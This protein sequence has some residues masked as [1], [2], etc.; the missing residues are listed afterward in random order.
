MDLREYQAKAKETDI[1]V[2][3]G[4]SKVLF[5]AL[6]L[7]E[8]LGVLA[9]ECKNMMRDQIEFP[10]PEFQRKVA[11]QLGH[12]LWYS[13]ILA[14]TIGVELESVAKDN[15]DLNLKRWIDSGV[16]EVL[17]ADFD[18]DFPAEQRLPRKLKIKFAEVSDEG[19]AK[20]SMQLEDE[21]IGDTID[22]NSRVNDNYRYHDTLHL[23]FMTILGWSPVMRKLLNRKR[24][25]DKEIDRVDDGARARDK[26]ETLV[27]YIYEKAKEK[28]FYKNVSTVDTGILNWIRLQVANLEIATATAKDWE[29]AILAG[30]RVHQQVVENKGGTILVDLDAKSLTYEGR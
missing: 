6:A 4:W 21:Q 5:C 7:Q 24:K 29:N 13:A 12:M 10:A 1:I 22:D 15:I 23:A 27:N 11:V 26:E 17:K 19:L 8:E 9:R 28:G 30:F 20:T 3:S 25:D 16:P 14:E 18:S 2:P